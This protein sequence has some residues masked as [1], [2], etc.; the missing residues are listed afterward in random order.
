MT[1]KLL[2]HLQIFELKYYCRVQHQL[3]TELVFWYVESLD[4][5]FFK[6]RKTNEIIKISHADYMGAREI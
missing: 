1:S 2:D 3:I 5:I 4:G 6:R